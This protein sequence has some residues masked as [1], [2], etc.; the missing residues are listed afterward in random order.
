MSQVRF[1]IVCIGRQGSTYL[2]R[3]L[4][5]HPDAACPGEIFSPQVFKAYGAEAVEAHLAERVHAL[6]QRVAGFKLSL[7]DAMF[8][9]ELIGIVKR[10]D[11]RVIHLTRNL[12][13]QFI[14]GQL[15]MAN[16][17]FTADQPGRGIT[18]ITTKEPELAAHFRW[19]RFGDSILREATSPMP[20]LDMSYERLIDPESHP[21]IYRF[22]ELEVLD[23]PPATRRQ[24]SGGQ[25]AGL[26]NY[27]EMK[28]AFA[29]T[30]WA[31]HF[32]E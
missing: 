15:A 32:L 23:L 7:Q 10:H 20:A 27:D 12:L 16:S 29:P 4:D 5:S 6:P 17:A 2:E 25:R 11:Y 19:V 21:E 22:L 26:T 8:H 13:D 30:R 14:S 24:R 3:L 31:A 1:A 28:L 18:E 9:P